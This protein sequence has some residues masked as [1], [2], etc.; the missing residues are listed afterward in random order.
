M[1]E[2][3]LDIAR[4]INTCLGVLYLLLA[5]AKMPFVVGKVE[6]HYALHYVGT[7]FL[8]LGFTTASATAFILHTPATPAIY[9]VTPPLVWMVLSKLI[10]DHK[11]G[12]NWMCSA[13]KIVPGWTCPGC[14]DPSKSTY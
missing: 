13:R 8:M 10:A 3:T 9:M 11:A 2:S 1:I 6:F 12:W 4:L 5:G 14:I 7:W